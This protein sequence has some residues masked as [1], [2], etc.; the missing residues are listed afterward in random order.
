MLNISLRFTSHQT[1]CKRLLFCFCLTTEARLQFVFQTDS[2]SGAPMPSLH[3]QKIARAKWEFLF[4]TPAE[5][6]ATRGEKSEI[7]F[8]SVLTLWFDFFT[9]M[10]FFILSFV[11]DVSFWIERV[12]DSKLFEEIYASFCAI[13]STRYHLKV[14][15]TSFSVTKLFRQWE[16]LE[17]LKFRD[18]TIVQLDLH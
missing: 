10:E 11:I 16:K 6:A 18:Y 15:Y 4:G 1:Q 17:C 5:E 7:T 9:R 8:S 13:N 2:G 3:C 14:W 12:A